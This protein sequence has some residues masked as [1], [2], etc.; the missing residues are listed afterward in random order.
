[1]TPHLNQCH[2]TSEYRPQHILYVAL[3]VF[4]LEVS[5]HC[6]TSGPCGISQRV[7]LQDV[8]LEEGMILS[9]GNFSL[10]LSCLKLA[11]ARHMCCFSSVRDGGGIDLSHVF[12][13]N[14]I[15]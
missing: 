1:M 9:D 12:V 14:S 8:A 11:E 5:F 7:S 4:I 6:F 13:F 2:S 10:L 3:T 15:L